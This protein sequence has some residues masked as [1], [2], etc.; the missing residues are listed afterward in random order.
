MSGPEVGA[1]DHS[2]CDTNDLVVLE[3]GD[4]VGD[5]RVPADGTRRGPCGE[6]L[7]NGRTTQRYSSPNAF[8]ADW[9]SF[10]TWWSREL[11]SSIILSIISRLLTFMV[12]A[13]SGT[14]RPRFSRDVAL[15]KSSW[16]RALRSRASISHI[17]GLGSSSSSKISAYLVPVGFSA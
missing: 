11:K 12:C 7:P 3:S 13:L 2:D 16:P 4:L 8:K 14:S 6:A 15:W 17:T 1:E 9:N 5:A 10:P